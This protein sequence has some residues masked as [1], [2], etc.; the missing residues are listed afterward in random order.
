MKSTCADVRDGNQK[1]DPW[2]SKRRLLA[3]ADVQ[4]GYH[5]DSLSHALATVER[6]GHESGAYVTNIR[7]DSQLITKQPLLGQGSK[8]Q[9]KNVNAR[10]L[11]H[12]DALFLLPSGEGTLTPQQK[13]D[14][15]TFVRDDGKG[16]IV[17]HA[18][19]LGFYDWPEFGE[20]I[21]ARMG[22]EFMGAVNVIVEQPRFPGAD[23]F[24]GS[25][26]AFLEQHPILSAPYSRERVEV[27]LR[28]DPESV[29]S[30]SR[31][32]R[33]DH[34]F[35]VVWTRR[36]GRGRVYHLSWGH[37]AATWDDPRFQMLVAKGIAWAMGIGA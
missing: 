13:A 31:S 10:N 32:K 15:L 16:L 7:T 28:I 20:L 29:P 3:V 36:Y 14:L 2:A 4:T 17:G 22:G 5:H 19:L 37:H 35:P 26:F 6:L 30:A 24:G 11:D 33:E 21:G 23:A 12:Y 27:I 18:G 1:A 34:D 8:Y 9:G 25:S